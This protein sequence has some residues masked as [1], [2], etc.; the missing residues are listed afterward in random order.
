MLSISS[1][2]LGCQTG[3]FSR[4][5]LMAHRCVRNSASPVR[6]GTKTLSTMPSAVP[7]L[8]SPTQ[9]SYSE[10]TE[11]EAQPWPTSCSHTHSSQP[12]TLQQCSKRYVLPSCSSFCIL[13][14]QIQIA[15]LLHCPHLIGFVATNPY[16][17]PSARL[18][19]SHIAQQL[20]GRWGESIFIAQV[21]KGED[22]VGGCNHNAVGQRAGKPQ[23]NKKDYCSL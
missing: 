22:T 7:S 4:H 5:L 23:W 13:Q 20:E 3:H 1:D 21:T 16:F 14:K 12:R 10:R 2:C 15:S 18:L 19:H 17:A 6:T 11:E 8:A 9:C